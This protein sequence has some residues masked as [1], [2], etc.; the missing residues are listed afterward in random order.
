MQ[1][2]QP[3]MLALRLAV[4]AGLLPYC[5]YPPFP[6]SIIGS[7]FVGGLPTLLEPDAFKAAIAA[8]TKTVENMP[9]VKG[10]RRCPESKY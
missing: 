6:K 4:K 3:Q 10:F 2:R 1:D 7:F 8:L 9:S 5:G